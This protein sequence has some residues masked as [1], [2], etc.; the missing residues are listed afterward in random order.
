MSVHSYER[1]QQHREKCWA[2][3]SPGGGGYLYVRKTACFRGSGHTSLLS[4]FV[5]KSHFLYLYP[6]S[7]PYPKHNYISPLYK[8]IKPKKFPSI[9]I[10]HT[11][12][13]S[14][15]HIT[16]Q[17]ITHKIKVHFPYLTISVFSK[18]PQKYLLKPHNF[19]R[20]NIGLTP[21]N[22]YKFANQK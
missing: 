7:I 22:Q 20:W 10:F 16:I 3:D 2:G 15:N 13:L 1:H 8:N 9:K 19:S 4:Q 11:P 18:F 17:K 6:L 5:S 14:L 21:I 12:Q